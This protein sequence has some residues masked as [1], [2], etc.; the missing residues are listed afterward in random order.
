M[1][2]IKKEKVIEIHHCTD[3]LFTFKTTRDPGFRFENG[4]FVMIGLNIDGRQVMR[5]YSIA[6]TNYEDYLNFIS[7]K[8]PNGPLTSHLQ[9]IQVGDEILVSQKS[10]GTLTIDRLW[11]T[12]RDGQ[13]LYLLATG[14]GLAPFMSIIA[15]PATYV[16]Y[17]N[18]M[19][20]HCCRTKEELIYGSYLSKLQDDEVIKEFLR[21]D[22]IYYPT[23]TQDPDENKGRITDLIYSGELDINKNMSRVMICGNPSMVN[24]LTDYFQ[25]NDW[26]LGKIDDP[27]HFTIE[28]AFVTRA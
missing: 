2:D 12:H 15:D 1:P 4:H 16:R 6:S 9:N 10:V 27:G 23:T 13:T 5:P 24:E 25:D 3:K 28:K 26:K 14:T 11:N 21:G 8:V 18:V 20:V 7:I 22:I 17:E 19:L